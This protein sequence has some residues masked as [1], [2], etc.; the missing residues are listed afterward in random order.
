MTTETARA[1]CFLAKIELR[2][3]VGRYIDIIKIG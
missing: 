1:L 2:I 3:E